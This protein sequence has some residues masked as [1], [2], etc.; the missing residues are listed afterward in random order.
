[1]SVVELLCSPGLIAPTFHKPLA[2]LAPIAAACMAAEM[3]LFSG[4][5]ICSGDPNY[6]PLVYWRVAAA[7]CAFVN[8]GR[9]VLSTV[10]H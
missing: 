7:I 1:M 8:Y 2:I 6:G 5:H 9:F 10:P 4:V 3:L